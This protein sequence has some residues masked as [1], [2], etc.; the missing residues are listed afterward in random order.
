MNNRHA[1]LILAHKNFGQLHKLIMLL[2]DPRNDIFVHVDKKAAFDSSEWTDVCRHSRLVF[3]DNRLHVNWGGVSIM[4]S[5]LALLKAATSTGGYSYYHLLSGMDL[6][7]TTLP[8]WRFPRRCA[9]RSLAWTRR[10][11]TQGTASPLCRPRK[12]R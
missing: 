4:R 10:R 7:V 9:P 11:T 1:Y 6:V 3:L 5:E 12:A 2:D 8:V